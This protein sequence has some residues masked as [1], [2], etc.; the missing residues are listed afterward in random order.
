[1]GWATRIKLK[2]PESV[3]L[4][5]RVFRACCQQIL[6]HVSEVCDEE[7]QLGMLHYGLA[8]SR[9][10]AADL[11]GVSRQ[12]VNNVVSGQGVGL[13]PGDAEE[14]DRGMRMHS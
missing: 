14:R 6:C 3:R 4:L 9:E 7:K 11:L 13:D 8:R 12:A 10:R 1:M 2:R 5:L